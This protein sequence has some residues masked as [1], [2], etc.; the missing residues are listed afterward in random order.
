MKK[1][2]QY[3]IIIAVNFICQNIFAQRD[4]IYKVDT[5]QIRCRILKTTADKYEY[6]FTDSALKIFTTK[7]LKSLVDSVKYNYYDSNLVQNKI[8]NKKIKRPAEEAITAVQKNWL[9]TFSIGLNLGNILEFNSPSGSDKKSLSGT[10]SVDLGL[11]YTKESSRLAITN[12]LHWLFSLQ[13]S[14][15]TSGAHIQRISD[16]INTLHDFSIAIG[17]TKK[18]NFNL[19]AKTATSVFTI[20]NGDYFKDI[21]LLGKSQ[22]FLSPYDVTI[23][24]GI[25]WQPGKYLRI[26]MSPYSFNL[27]GVKNQQ[28]STT[29]V[30]ITDVDASGNYKKFLFKRL[31]AEV[32]FWY[33]RRLKT[34]L[35]M[36]YRLGISSNYFEK[37]AKNGLLDG[38]FIT[39]IK[40]V[41]NLYLT[42][43]AELKGDFSSTPFKPYYNQSVLLSF[44]KSF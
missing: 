10:A 41:K 37:I 44:S 2:K 30:F 29:G 27:Y 11:N 18:W 6:A 31:G 42:H 32:N 40:L 14:G 1:I 21:N 17:K 12:E 34:W 3:I 38:L 8:F 39:K 19:I 7:I 13:K 5:T 36:Q 24:P 15:L 26:S 33:D 25:K 23:S 22:A 20:Y 35:E 16:D 4:I 9:F 43:R 28:V